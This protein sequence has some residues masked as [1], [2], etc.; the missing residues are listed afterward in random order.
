MKS[1]LISNPESSFDEILLMTYGLNSVPVWPCESCFDLGEMI[2]E[3]QMMPELESCSD[4]VLELLDREHIGKIMC[5]RNGGMFVDMVYCEP[6]CYEP[7]DINIEI[8]KAEKCFFR[9]LVAPPPADDKPTENM[10]QWVSLPCPREQLD[11]LAKSFDTNIEDMVYYDFQSA[12]PQITD[13]S[14]GNMNEI[15]ELNALAE[16]LSTL[17]HSDF[18]KLK[19]VMESQDFRE[20][21]DAAECLNCLDGYG[22]VVNIF[23]ES[24]F[25]KEYLSRNLPTNFDL[26]VLED[27]DLHD[28]GSKILS[29]KGSQATS[30]GIICGRNMDLFSAITVQPEQE[31]EE[32]VD[33]AFEM[34]MGDMSL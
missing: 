13:E 15:D 26:S 7:P 31:I 17:T 1:L 23:N 29:Y 22:F 30:Y 3:N 14:F 11:G 21:S 33:E 16:K 12:L 25:G 28:F 27:I 5:E 6:A 2:I 20:I 4:E 24:E 32:E 19:A 18:I 34:E 9:L 10:A 8:G